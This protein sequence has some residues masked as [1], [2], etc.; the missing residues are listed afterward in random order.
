MLSDN[1]EKGADYAKIKQTIVISIMNENLFPETDRCHTV[2]RF[3]EQSEGFELS[4]IISL[5]YLELSKIDITKPVSEMTAVERLGAYIKYASD[6]SKSEYV[7]KLLAKKEGAVQMADTILR[8]VSEEEILRERLEAEKWKQYD[9]NSMNTL[10]EQT[11]EEEKSR[12]F[13]K[14][15]TEIIKLFIQ[16]KLEDQC[17]ENAIIERLITRFSMEEKVA[18]LL[19]NEVKN[20]LGKQP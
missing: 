7:E 4:S 20:S 19:V 2:F 1:L 10:I 3:M 14:G 16:D 17:A 8:K 11:L 13:D 5:H 18:E 9:I 15:K 6:S 12:S